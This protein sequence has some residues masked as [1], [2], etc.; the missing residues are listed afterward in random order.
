MAT[1]PQVELFINQPVVNITAGVPSAS[2]G[3]GTVTS[4]AVGNLAPL[5]TSNV[6]T[7]TLAANITFTLSNASA[8][9]VL[10]GPTSGGAAAPTYRALVVADLPANVVLTSGSYSNPNWITSLA[11]TKI[12]GTP[13]TRAG[14]GITDAQATLVSGTNIKT[15]DGVSVLGAGNIT[16]NQVPAGLISMWA[17]TSPPTGWALC[18]GAGGTPD[19]R[20]MFI[21]GYDPSDADY[22][23]IGDNG[24]AKTV[25]L[26][27]TEIPA[28]THGITVG[29]HSASTAS[30][31]SGTNFQTHLAAASEN[32][33]SAGG[34]TAHENRPPYYTLAYII[35]L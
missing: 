1:I 17:G 35:K 25:A 10:A 28:H 24:G 5:F 31:D 34:G 15:I 16:T 18:N 33:G 3:R 8:N 32:T 4:V 27:L 30:F 7:P 9:A 11:W 19:L 22:N 29:P 20:G 26:A 12:T 13:T 14:Y 2:T 21:V 6:A 23:A